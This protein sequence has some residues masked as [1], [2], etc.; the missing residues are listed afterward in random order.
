MKFKDVNLG[1]KN[2]GLVL[3]LKNRNQNF[4]VAQNEQDYST[5]YH[6]LYQLGNNTFSIPLFVLPILLSVS[7]KISLFEVIILKITLSACI[8]HI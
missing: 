5:I 7:S 2:L 8:P 6:V 3:V 4:L 1:Q